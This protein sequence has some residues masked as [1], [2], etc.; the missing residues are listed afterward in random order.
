M[1]RRPSRTP[2]GIGRSAP[3]FSGSGPCIVKVEP[4]FLFVFL[5]KWLCSL[6]FFFLDY[7]II[8]YFCCY[9]SSGGTVAIT[10]VANS[11]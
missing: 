4:Q 1:A 11:F 8:Y 7:K 5:D 3:R 6:Y 2:I 10:A 9:C